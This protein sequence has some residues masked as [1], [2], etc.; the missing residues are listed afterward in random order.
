MK[1]LITLFVLTCTLL[2]LPFSAL[3]VL[4]G[5]Y[6]VSYITNSVGYDEGWTSNVTAAALEVGELVPGD[7]EL[8][9][10]EGRLDGNPVDPGVFNNHYRDI[11]EYWLVLETINSGYIKYDSGFNGGNT[12]PAVNTGYNTPNEYSTSWF[13]GVYYWL[14]DSL[15]DSGG[16]K[17]GLG[18]LG[19]TKTFTLESTTSL[20]FF[21]DDYWNH[22]NIGGTT[23]TLTRISES[24][25]PEPSTMILLGCGL[26]GLVGVTRRRLKQ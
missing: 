25:V 23:I 13:L 26:I 3:A 2:V 22:D 12:N 21:W 9:I 7:Y 20:W 18:G 24:A 10:V 6:E 11:D 14:G 16:V 15:S 8:Q 5:T 19:S 4:I 1:A 17:D